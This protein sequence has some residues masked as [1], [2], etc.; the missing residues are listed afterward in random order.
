MGTLTEK[1]YRDGMQMLE[2]AY[3]TDI[4]KETIQVYWRVLKT[5]I[6]EDFF[7]ETIEDV[8]VSE[9]F[10]PT[11]STLLKYFKHSTPE[12]ILKKYGMD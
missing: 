9:R 5:R 6:S 4:K 7:I 2:A 10:F 3:S 11:I 8:I 12:E 1:T